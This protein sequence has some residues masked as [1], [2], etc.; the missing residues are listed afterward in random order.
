MFLAEGSRILKS[1]QDADRIEMSLIQKQR[2][3]DQVD[4]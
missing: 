4:K 2:H 1:E 3:K